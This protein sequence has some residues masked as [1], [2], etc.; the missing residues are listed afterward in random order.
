MVESDALHGQGVFDLQARQGHDAPGRWDWKKYP[1]RKFFEVRSFRRKVP[2]DQVPAAPLS[3][4][5]GTPQGL[6]PSNRRAFRDT[7]LRS[8]FVVNPA[9][10]YDLFVLTRYE[11][12]PAATARP[13]T[14]P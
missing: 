5:L 3:G 6:V 12:P 14:N 11:K 4:Y 2:V 10:E 9:G 13:A 8:V 7:S 1:S